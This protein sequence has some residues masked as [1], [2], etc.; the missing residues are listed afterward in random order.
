MPE[1][2]CTAPT[3]PDF[4][5]YVRFCFIWIAKVKPL[6]QA[7][8]TL[9]NST[10]S[11]PWR[12]P[13]SRE[14]WLLSKQLLYAYMVFISALSTLPSPY[15]SGQT[16]LN[17]K[18]ENISVTCY[19]SILLSVHHHLETILKHS[20]LSDRNDIFVE[21]NRLR[22]TAE[23]ILVK[24]ENHVEW[25]ASAAQAE[26]LLCEHSY[27]RSDAASLLAAQPSFSSNTQ[28]HSTTTRIMKS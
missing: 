15:T 23:F 22:D 19:F 27:N 12:R 14:F 18:C 17:N 25:L 26:L 10:E 16:V 2:S 21:C 13:T 8:R 3:P 5:N 11:E 6:C 4:L 7:I 28:W 9:G 20:D 1:L 24:F